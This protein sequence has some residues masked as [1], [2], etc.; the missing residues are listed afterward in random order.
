MS[1]YTLVIGNKK[2]SSWS[3]RPWIW[4]RHARIPFREKR[5]ALFTDTYREELRP[6]RSHHRVPVLVDGDVQVWETLAILEY[7]AEHFAHAHAWPE[8]PEARAVARS[9]SMEMHAGF[10]TMRRAFPMNCSKRFPGF[11]YGDEVQDDIDRVVELWELC[12]GM[13]YDQGNWLFGRFCI[14]DAMYVP[15]AL[16]F[17]GYDVALSDV[18]QAYVDTVLSDGHVRDWI[19]TG[20]AEKEVIEG[21]EIQAPSSPF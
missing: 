14:V 1:D 12:R 17:H 21:N 20:Q 15:V 11:V 7:L 4:M 3:L 13:S 19:R 8:H 16:R 5:I 2:Y 6:Y 9:A 18:A 10:K